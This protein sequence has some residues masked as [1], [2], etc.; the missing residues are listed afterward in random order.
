MPRCGQSRSEKQKG[1]AI[2][3]K[4]PVAI[5]IY[6][7]RK[8]AEADLY[9]TLKK[10]KE[11]G[12]DGVEFAGLYGHE[13]EKIRDM[14]AEIGIVPLSAHVPYLDMIKDPEGVLGAYRTIGCRFVA[15][16][17]LTPEYR[18]GTENFPEVI[19]NVA[20]LGEVA[21]K[22]GMTLLYHNHDFEFDKLDGKYALD[23]LYEE[24]PASLL[25][26]ELD[27]CWVNVGGEDPAEYLTK[28]SGR[29]PVLHLK[30]FVGSKS[31]NMYELIGIDGKKSEQSE[32]FAFRPVGY[33]KQDFPK[34]LAA[35]EPAG[36]QWV[37]VEQ[38]QPT[39]EN[40]PMECAEMSRN[41]LKSI[42]L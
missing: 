26:T 29:S 3:K 12:Y 42:G 14:C 37:V 11:I 6:S 21:N 38:D 18:P 35:A 30:D 23:V 15:V 39:E 41:Y 31:A 16:P 2:M 4:F 27:T 28:Y 5:Q 19:K 40:T 1:N 22:L 10:L 7:V 36:V 33:G 9:G 13:P 25:Q 20:K 34:I 24:V 17:Y 8:D 32:K